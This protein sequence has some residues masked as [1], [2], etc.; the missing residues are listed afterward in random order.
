M[1]LKTT[2]RTAAIAAAA[3]LSL[4]LPLPT[5]AQDSSYTPGSVWFFSN[6][7]VEPGQ[8]ER[9]MDYLAANWKK[10]QELGRKEGVIVSYH[11]LSVNA[12]RNGEPDLVLAV[13]FKDYRSNAEQQAFQKKVEAMLAADARKQDVAAGERGVMRKLVGNMQLQ[14]LVL[15]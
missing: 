13:E 5:L 1:R 4:A 2:L 7:Q 12:P 10:V 8:F 6:V 11:V 3:A 15:K 9:Y 14:E